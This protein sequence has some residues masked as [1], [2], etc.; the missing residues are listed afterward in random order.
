MADEKKAAPDV[1]TGETHVSDGATGI[2]SHHATPTAIVNNNTYNVSAGDHANVQA[3][4]HVSTQQ[5]EAEWLAQQR[6]LKR[7]QVAEQVLPKLLKYLDALLSPLMSVGWGPSNKTAEERFNDHWAPVQALHNEFLE[8]GNQIKTHFGEAEAQVWEDIWK[9]KC[10]LWAKQHSVLSDRTMWEHGYGEHQAEARRLLVIR[11]G[12]TF[13]P[14]AQ[15]T[16]P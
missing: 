5:S 11:A 13:R 16:A 1:V 4:Q 6:L 14:I 12:A 8:V 7:A 3:G 15:M 9:Y 2:A 10:Q